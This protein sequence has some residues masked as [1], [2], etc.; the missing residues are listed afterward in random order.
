MALNPAADIEAGTVEDS[1]RWEPSS[2]TLPPLHTWPVNGC[3]VSQRGKK[4]LV[5]RVVPWEG[6]GAG[7][8]S[9]KGLFPTT[10]LGQSSSRPGD[11]DP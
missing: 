11:L 1:A 4:K 8:G 10:P 6:P 2:S 9:S 7:E 3:G 5:Q